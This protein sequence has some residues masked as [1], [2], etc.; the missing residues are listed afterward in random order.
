MGVVLPAVGCHIS[1]HI[2]LLL[3]HLL[4]SGWRGD[5]IRLRIHVELWCVEQRGLKCSFQFFSFSVTNEDI[6]DRTNTA[7]DQVGK[8]AIATLTVYELCSRHATIMS[9]IRR[10]TVKYSASRYQLLR[11]TS[12]PALKISDDEGKN[13]ARERKNEK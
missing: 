11:Q 10:T 13:C 2:S 4:H 3:H 8:S 6:C 1:P 5:C 12:L 9:E 7:S